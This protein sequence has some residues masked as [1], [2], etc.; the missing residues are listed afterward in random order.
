M[1]GEVK[2]DFVVEPGYFIL[3]YQWMQRGHCLSL[4]FDK[5]SA[6]EVLPLVPVTAIMFFGFFIKF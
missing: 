1:L 4:R 2:L 5:R 3:M 6:T